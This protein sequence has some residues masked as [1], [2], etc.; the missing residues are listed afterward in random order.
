MKRRSFLIALAALAT[1]SF[2]Y[3]SNNQHKSLKS[4]NS[5]SS[6]SDYSFIRSYLKQAFPN[7]SLAHILEET[8]ENTFNAD[9]LSA[10]ALTEQAFGL[11]LDDLRNT[12]PSEGS[13]LFS[14][15][16]TRDLNKLNITEVDGWVLS[17]SEQAL[18]ALFTMS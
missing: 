2:H 15:R 4:I 7:K 5:F 13:K 9:G 3:L 6:R 1:P 16:R 8:H 14:N 11:S 12:N 17:K 10:N 18:F